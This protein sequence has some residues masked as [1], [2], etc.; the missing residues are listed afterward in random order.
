M[1]YLPAFTIKINQNV[2]KYTSPMD[3]M[4]YDMY[5]ATLGCEFIALSQDLS[6]T[7]SPLD[8]KHVRVSFRVTCPWFTSQG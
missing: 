8:M 2:G 5:V 4:G 1:V 6:K 3:P 7:S